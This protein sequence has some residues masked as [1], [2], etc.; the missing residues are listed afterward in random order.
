MSASTHRRVRFFL[1]SA[2]KSHPLDACQF[3]FKS[4]TTD[5]LSSIDEIAIIDLDRP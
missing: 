4:D 2:E 3:S 1:S 5:I